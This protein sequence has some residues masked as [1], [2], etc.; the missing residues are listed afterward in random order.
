MELFEQL[1]TRLWAAL[2]R[3]DTPDLSQHERQLLHHLEPERPVNL[4]WLAGH[5]GLPK[6]T[7]STIVK[8]LAERGFVHRVRDPGNERRLAITLTPKGHER[9]AADTVLDPARLDAALAAVPEPDRAAMLA[10]LG[11]LADAAEALKP[12]GRRR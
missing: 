10:A 12:S 5:L 8:R 4:G 7:T 6:S 2:N 11:K 9:V 3:P 1:Y